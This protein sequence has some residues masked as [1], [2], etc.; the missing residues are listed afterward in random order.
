[1]ATRK[2]EATDSKPKKTT[3]RR[4]RKITEEMIRDRAY[5]ISLYESGSPLEHWLAAERELLPST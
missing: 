5:Y 4:S 2:A 3:I 1:M